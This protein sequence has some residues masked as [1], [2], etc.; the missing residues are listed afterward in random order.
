MGTLVMIALAV[1]VWGGYVLYNN[2]D[3]K[4]LTTPTQVP[5]DTQVV[6]PD[7][8]AKK[9]VDSIAAPSTA[10]APAGS[11]KFIFETTTKKPGRLNGMLSYC[12]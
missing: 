3:G 12:L 6:V 1:I 5:V 4:E 8:T 9:P 2:N 11:Y 10:G 7:T